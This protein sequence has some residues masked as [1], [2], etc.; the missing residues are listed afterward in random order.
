LITDERNRQHDFRID[1]IR[2]LY[3]RPTDETRRRLALTIIKKRDRNHTGV[4]REFAGIFE[5]D[6]APKRD[7]DRIVHTYRIVRR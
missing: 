1:S 2:D 5:S 4:R 7:L 3:F 6:G